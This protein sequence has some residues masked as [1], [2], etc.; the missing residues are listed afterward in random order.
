MQNQK[1][2]MDVN[3]KSTCASNR[4]Q[5]NNETMSCGDSL[6]EGNI[7]SLNGFQNVQNSQIPS[8]KSNVKSDC[9]EKIDVDISVS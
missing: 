9:N 7:D 5:E 8:E 4:V 6:S 1:E 3:Q 2:S